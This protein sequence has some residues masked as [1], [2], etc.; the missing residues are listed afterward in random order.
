MGGRSEEVAPQ[1]PKF[2]EA[3]WQEE[4]RRKLLLHGMEWVCFESVHYKIK[5][6]G[7]CIFHWYNG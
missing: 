6:F 1:R 2:E 5:T 7:S 3:E 4:G